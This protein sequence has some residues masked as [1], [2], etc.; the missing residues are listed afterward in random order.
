MKTSFYGT[1]ALATAALVAG[2]AGDAAAQQH[3]GGRIQIE[4]HGY[5]Q[6][7]LVGVDQDFNDGNGRLPTEAGYTVN[8]GH[9]VIN[10]DQKTNA[11]VCF[12]GQTTLDNGITV[13]VEVQLEAYS[14]GNHVD[15][16]YLFLESDRFGR[17]MVG[18]EDG[19][20]E[21]LSVNAPDGG[22]SVDAAGDV[23]TNEFF[24]PVSGVNDDVVVS[25]E[26]GLDGDSNKISYITPRLYGF[27]AGVSF[28]PINNDD[29]NSPDPGTDADAGVAAALNYAN[30]FA[31]GFGVAAT[32]AIVN[33]RNN[34]SSD[35]DGSLNGSMEWRFGGQLSYLGFTVGGAYK[36]TYGNDGAPVAGT[37]G[38]TVDPTGANSRKLNGSA[39]SV[40]GTYETGP[41]TVGISYVQGS[42]VGW[43]IP[44]TGDYKSKMGTLAGTYV[45]GP[46]IRLRGGFFLFD[47]DAER[48]PDAFAGVAGNDLVASINNNQAALNAGIQDTSDS[49]G[50][51]GAIALTASF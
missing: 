20:G 27:Q 12:V 43:N 16:T 42:S 37:L 51:G 13:G 40:G 6:Q 49:S 32:A 30:V 50:W 1:T 15:E 7:W 17:L 48:V 47:Q 36:Q 29:S 3:G 5:M 45:L 38:G 11:E 24:L 4:V 46:G 2:I 9:K 19:V 23:V 28:T 8:Q 35:P 10:V 34:V 39:W 31:N 41:Y 33:F 14:A 22:I 25:T 18:A 26:A 21:Q 44:G